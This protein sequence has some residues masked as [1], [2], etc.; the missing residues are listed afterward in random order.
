MNTKLKTIVAAL[1]LGLALSSTASHASLI[2]TLFSAGTNTVQDQDA[3]RLLDST[4]AVKAGGLQYVVGD[5][6]QSILRFDSVNGGTIGDS[7]P[8][9][10]QLTGYS[11]LIVSSITDLN[12]G[13]LALN[14]P[15][16]LHF[17]LAGDTL[18][19]IFEHTS[20]TALNFANTP[21]VSIANILG[22]SPVASFGLSAAG[23][24]FWF[25]DTI[26]NSSAITLAV[27]SG[28]VA[29]GAFGLTMLTGDIPL[30]AK[31]ILSP[32]DFAMHDLIGDASVFGRET[33]VNTGWQVSSNIN[34]SFNVPE[35]ESLALL[36]IGLLGMGASL[37]KR[38]AV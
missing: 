32:I 14:D 16:R 3:E 4:G 30:I 2:N 36:G 34:A 33:G 1:G 21:A 24:D 7:L 22:Q 5:S 38:K 29:A 26:N 10:Y 8:A 17:G 18:V 20:G 35:P 9:P 6:I 12:G 37:R 31:G 11:N 23:G 25:A 13:A 15:I 27:G 19:S 28:Q